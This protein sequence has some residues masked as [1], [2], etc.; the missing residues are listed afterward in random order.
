MHRDPWETHFCELFQKVVN[1]PWCI[2]VQEVLDD[3]MDME[4]FPEPFDTEK[5]RPICKK[6]GWECVNKD[7]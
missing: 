3:N 5:A 7:V 1:W 2:E 4:L 6:C